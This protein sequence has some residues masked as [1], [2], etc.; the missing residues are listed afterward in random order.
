LGNKAA[1]VWKKLE[2]HIK[3]IQKEHASC[4]EWFKGIQGYDYQIVPTAAQSHPIAN[5]GACVL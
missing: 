1:Q 5:S 3:Q 2:R 4:Q